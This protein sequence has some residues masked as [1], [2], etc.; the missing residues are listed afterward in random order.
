MAD[1]PP[2][3]ALNPPAAPAV[4]ASSTAEAASLTK[5]P[6]PADPDDPTHVLLH[7]P[8]HVRS[9]TLIILAVI[10]VLATLRFAAAFFIPLML[11]F[12]FSYAL[13]PIVEW[14]QRMKVPR[15]LSAA[16]LILAILGSA[17]ASIY[18]FSD[19]ASQLVDTL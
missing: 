3:L 16:V 2:D 7:V 9:V 18:S 5:P 15:A 14:L 8:V 13:S 17:G 1:S 10:L 12:M 6:L 19:D 11:G 4:P